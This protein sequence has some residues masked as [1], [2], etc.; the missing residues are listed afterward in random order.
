MKCFILSLN[1]VKLSGVF[2]KFLSKTFKNILKLKHFGI[3]WS[4][5]DY[6]SPI[7]EKYPKKYKTAS[8]KPSGPGR[9]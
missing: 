8:K 7:L 9:L 2:L 3:F 1:T 4:M 6:T 5:M